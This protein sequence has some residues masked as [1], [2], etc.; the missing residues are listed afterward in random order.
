MKKEIDKIDTSK[1]LQTVYDSEGVHQQIQVIES[2]NKIG[3]EIV[4]TLGIGLE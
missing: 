4:A 2:S 3:I 1:T